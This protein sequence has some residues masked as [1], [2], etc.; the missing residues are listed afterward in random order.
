MQHIPNSLKGM[1]K[2]FDGKRYVAWGTTST[3][4][5]AHEM[6]ESYRKDGYLARYTE[7]KGGKNGRGYLVWARR[8]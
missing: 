8:K 3:K 6:A 1:H 7:T 4:Q 2:F 5:G